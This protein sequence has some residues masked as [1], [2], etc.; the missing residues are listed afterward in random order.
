MSKYFNA[1]LHNSIKVGDV[2]Y[3]VSG[4]NM[5]LAY[6]FKVV[7]KTAKTIVVKELEERVVSGHRNGYWESAPDV[8]TFRAEPC[9]VGDIRVA[10]HVV[11]R[12]EARDTHLA[13]PC[14]Y[15]RGCHA[16]YKWN[17][18]GTVSCCDLD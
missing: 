4:Y 7:K 3:Y 9:W 16:A 11:K 5:T 13:I 8:D 1:E 14:N 10:K 18:T 15:T 2:F 17:G 6:W 12:C